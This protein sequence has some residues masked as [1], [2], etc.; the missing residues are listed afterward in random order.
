MCKGEDAEEEEDAGGEQQG[1]KVWALRV[2]ERPDERRLL[3]AG[4]R[5]SSL[6]NEGEEELWTE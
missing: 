3:L 2:L 6:S 1:E 5:S 4:V